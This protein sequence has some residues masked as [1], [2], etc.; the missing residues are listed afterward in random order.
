MMFLLLKASIPGLPSPWEPPSK[1]SDHTLVLE[2]GPSQPQWGKVR[3]GCATG[4]EGLVNECTAK[5]CT[6]SKDEAL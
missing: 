6:S 2:G 5:T 4:R 1:S 3:K